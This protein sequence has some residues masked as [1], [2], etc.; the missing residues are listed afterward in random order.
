MSSD[1]L[2]TPDEQLDEWCRRFL[3]GVDSNR[4]LLDVDSDTLADAK[5]RYEE[6]S[7]AWRESA[8]LHVE[9]KAAAERK[10]GLRKPFRARMR[11]L[12]R[13]AKYCRVTDV[14][15][16]ELGAPP[17]R[18]ERRTSPHDIPSLEPPVVIADPGLGRVGFRFSQADG[19]R[20]KP[21]GVKFL[22]GLYTDVGSPGV[23]R[24]LFGCSRMNY[25]HEVGNTEPVVLRYEFAWYGAG[26]T[27]RYCE[28]FDV[29]V[30]S[31]PADK[32]AC[33]RKRHGGQDES[34]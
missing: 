5:A 19:S 18:G 11:V 8:R 1:Y 16:A 28:P 13:Q 22:T 21:R 34:A 29:A 32:G 27:S 14:L 24:M 15:R 33:D 30:T 9:A 20:R 23:K 17:L 3:A 25:T 4:E 7:R 6:W 26:G 31:A 2:P 10:A 12:V